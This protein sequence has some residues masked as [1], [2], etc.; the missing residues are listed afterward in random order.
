MKSSEYP[1]KKKRTEFAAKLE[2]ALV[3]FANER[4][5][6]LLEVDLV[7]GV[8]GDGALVDGERADG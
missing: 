6:T 1:K 3:D 4:L 7:L 8:P 5:P 2:E